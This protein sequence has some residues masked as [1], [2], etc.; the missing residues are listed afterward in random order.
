MGPLPPL[1]LVVGVVLPPLLPLPH[2]SVVVQA[3]VRQLAVGIVGAV[4]SRVLAKKR[5]QRDEN[6][7]ESYSSPNL[8]AG[9]E[10]NPFLIL[11]YCFVH[12]ARTHLG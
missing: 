9:F 8:H 2:D 7:M 3:I 4:A 1:P 11:L 6:K 5:K 10:V 12:I